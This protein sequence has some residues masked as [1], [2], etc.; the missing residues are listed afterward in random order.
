MCAH[1][2]ATR[3]PPV[4]VTGTPVQ[5]LLSKVVGDDVALQERAVAAAPSEG[6]GLPALAAPSPGTTP[7]V[8]PA[9]A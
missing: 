1:T 6:T 5:K 3:Y 8:E 4:F 9:P 2:H 7:P